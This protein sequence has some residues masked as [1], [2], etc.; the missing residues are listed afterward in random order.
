MI[1]L[2]HKKS[3]EKL[4]P[5]SSYKLVVASSCTGRTGWFRY[6][7]VLDTFVFPETHNVH[8]PGFVP[9]APD[10]WFVVSLGDLRLADATNNNFL[11]WWLIQFDT[12]G[13]VSVFQPGKSTEKL[14]PARLFI[15][16][17]R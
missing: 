2:S 8:V 5:A 6:A 7:R 9:K 1:G 17:L 10:T 14:R 12:L 13:S 4:R 11:I 15:L 16:S 3:T